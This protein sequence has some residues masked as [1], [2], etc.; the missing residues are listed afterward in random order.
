MKKILLSLAVCSLIYAETTQATQDGQNTLETNKVESENANKP[1]VKPASGATLLKDFI[2]YATLDGYARGEYIYTDGRDGYG[3]GFRVFFRPNITTGEVK[4]FSFTGGLFFSK[5]SAAPDGNAIADFIGGPRIFDVKNEAAID[6]FGISNLYVSKK[7][8]KANTML[9]VGAMQIE[10][11]LNA[12]SGSY[13]D[14]GM[15]ALVK[16]SSLKGMEFLLATYGSWMT[17]NIGL[18]TYASNTGKSA[19]FGLANVL[20]IV[21]AKGNFAFA[22]LENL[23]ATL[24]YAYADRLIDMMLFGDV[25]YKF[26]FDNNAYLNVLVQVGATIMNEN[27]HFQSKASVLSSYYQEASKI[28]KGWARNRGVYNIRLDWG[29]GGYSGALGYAGSFAEAYGAMLDSAGQLKIGGTLWSSLVAGGV[30]G[31]GFTGSGSYHGS[32]IRV[33]Y[34]EQ[35][36]KLGGW[37]FGLGL[38]YV[39]GHNRIAQMSKGSNRIKGTAA[40]RGGATVGKAANLTMD[41]DIFEIAPKISY[42][43][44]K[45]L[46]TSLVFAQIVGDMVVNRTKVIVMYK[47]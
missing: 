7:F 5:G 34:T 42:S 43:F 16:N 35:N 30:I 45:N 47:F 10:T 44:T 24:Y 41:A 25:G 18:Q 20:S 27:P 6:V 15:G 21:G 3:Q 29:V 36:Y 40:S 26:K 33:A 9:R 2:E 14:R 12:P 23:T 8:E 13:G 46:S 4:G 28:D 17:D 31:F 38:T 22:G 32:D 37:Q 11:P 19:N 1:K 39:G